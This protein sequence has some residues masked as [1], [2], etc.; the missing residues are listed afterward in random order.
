MVVFVVVSV[1]VFSRDLF[2]C[3]RACLLVHS[4]FMCVCMSK[5][6]GVV[7]TLIYLR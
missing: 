6:I 4:I 7:L 5:R 1:V 2:L 3:W